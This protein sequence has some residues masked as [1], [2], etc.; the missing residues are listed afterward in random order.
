MLTNGK[1]IE[2]TYLGSEFEET[3][4]LPNLVDIQLKSYEKF[5]QMDK[6][7][8]GEAPALQGLEEVFQSIFPIESQSGDMLLEYIEYKLDVKNIKL[9]ETECKKKGLSYAVP[10]KAKVNLVFQ[11]T[12]EIRQKNIYVGDVPLMTSRG[13][14]IINGAERVVVSQI[15]RSPGVIFSHDK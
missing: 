5:L 8:A 6:L 1:T 12:G 4:D 7:V 14:F 9:T 10:I 13:T 3:M 11:E 15:H 2:R